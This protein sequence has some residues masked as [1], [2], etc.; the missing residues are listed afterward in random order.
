[1]F[2]QGFFRTIV[3]TINLHPNA[4][5]A[6]SDN[7]KYPAVSSPIRKRRNFITTRFC[8]HHLSVQIV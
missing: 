3:E 1:M 6:P 7:E 4:E 8:K 2:R 5:Y